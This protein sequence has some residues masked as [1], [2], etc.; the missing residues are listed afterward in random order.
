MSRYTTR[1]QHAVHVLRS[2]GVVT[3]MHSDISSRMQSW[4]AHSAPVEGRLLS[5]ATSTKGM[6]DAHRE[7]HGTTCVVNVAHGP[8]YKSLAPILA[9]NKQLLCSA[10][11]Y[12]CILHSTPLSDRP[13]AWDK[14]I[15]LQDA[16]AS[17]CTRCLWLDAD[18]I[19]RRPFALP[20]VTSA[21]VLAMRDVNGLNT[22][23]M[24]LRRSASV[25]ELLLRSWNATQFI[26]SMWW[27]QR[28]LRF[29]LDTNLYLRGRT[30]LL[31]GLVSYMAQPNSSAPIFHAAGCFS[32]KGFRK[33]TCR[34]YLNRTL[35]VAQT[36]GSM[37]AF[38]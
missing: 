31:T 19:I 13:A 35:S 24:L 18:T 30:R 23:V 3:K 34:V 1:S 25:N 15:A 33:S 14:I 7:A 11:G 29:V 6:R 21:D 9:A 5:Q 22:G 4:R 20:V 38:P 36:A 8:Q 37:E 28:A 32:S 10:C 26:H 12:R 27:E 17:G 2:V 16:F